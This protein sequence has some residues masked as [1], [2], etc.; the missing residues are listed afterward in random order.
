MFH[1][2]GHG[3]DPCMAQQN[4]PDS[5]HPF[6]CSAQTH[7]IIALVGWVSYVSPFLPMKQEQEI[8]FSSKNSIELPE[9]LYIY[10]FN[11]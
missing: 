4:A 1:T 3:V 8:T 2:A 11:F 6:S 9:K 10:F 5:P 7:H